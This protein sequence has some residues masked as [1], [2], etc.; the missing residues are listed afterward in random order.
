M[1]ICR[2]Y[3]WTVGNALSEEQC[4]IL[5]RLDPQVPNNPNNPNNLNNSIDNY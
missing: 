2:K 5:D 1:I 3:C 4:A